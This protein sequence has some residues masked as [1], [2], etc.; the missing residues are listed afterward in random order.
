[1]EREDVFEAAHRLLFELIGSGA[2]TGLRIDHVDGL[3]NPREYFEK[4]QSRYAEIF[5]LAPDS[6]GLYLLVEKIL[7]GPERLRKRLGGKRHHRLRFH[8]P[9]DGRPRRSR[10]GKGDDAKPTADSSAR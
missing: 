1:M 6:R 5:H 2:V 9:G 7:T 3:W 4:L 8:E 10:G